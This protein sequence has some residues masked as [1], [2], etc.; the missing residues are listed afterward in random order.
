MRTVKHI[1]YN[2][3]PDFDVPEGEA[4]EALYNMAKDAKKFIKNNHEMHLKGE[5]SKKLLVHCK[6]GCGRTGTMISL[7]NAMLIADQSPKLSLFSIVRRLREQRYSLVETSEQ[8]KFLYTLM[9][10]YAKEKL[11]A[12]KEYQLK[13]QEFL[14]NYDLT[15]VE[16]DNQAD[17]YAAVIE[18]EMPPFELIIGSE[19][20]S[21]QIGLNM[22]KEFKKKFVPYSSDIDSFGDVLDK[23][24]LIITPPNSDA[25]ELET[26]LT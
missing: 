21:W 26:K 16:V 24:V 23:K 18:A 10:R 17:F 5:L 1:H 20:D 19:P 12:I 22:A 8:Y 13:K 14:Q 6:A 7:V 4:V 15:D 25:E 3:W 11:T 9:T 2:H